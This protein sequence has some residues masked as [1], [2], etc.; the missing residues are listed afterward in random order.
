MVRCLIAACAVV[1]VFTTTAQG[2]TYEWLDDKGVVHFTDTPDNIPSKYRKRIKVRESVKGEEIRTTTPTPETQPSEPRA[3]AK[4]EQLYGGHDMKWWQ[5]TYESLYGE[6]N[7][8]QDN[9]PA[10]RERLAIL[11]HKRIVYQKG[12]DRVSYNE[13]S[14]EIERDEARIKELQQK[15]VELD[16]EASRAGV[17]SGWRQ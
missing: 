2:E 3:S 9:L 7:K 10:K 16:A 13:L 17:P 1:F 5:T 6:I 12:S 15:I 11:R 14:A 8:I 4:E